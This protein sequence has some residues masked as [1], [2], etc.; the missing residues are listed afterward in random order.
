MLISL[1]LPR[2][3]IYA[4]CAGA[5]RRARVVRIGDV[6]TR[7]ATPNIPHLVPSGYSSPFDVGA[8]A[9]PPALNMLRWMAQKEALKQDV[10]LIGPPGGQ[11]RR[12]ALWWATTGQREVEYLALSSDTTEAELKQRREVID[13]TVHYV[14]SLPVRAALAGRLLVL[15][16]VERAER[17]VLPVRSLRPAPACSL[18][19]RWTSPYSMPRLRRPSITCSRTVR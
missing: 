14:D 4:S 17:N 2:T 3:S 1:R 19:I 13:G 8:E 15:D 18:L 5:L 11:L 6:T 10:M 16:G 7:V 9:S 12:L